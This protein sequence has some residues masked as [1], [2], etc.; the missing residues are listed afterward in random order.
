MRDLYPR[1]QAAGRALTAHDR[2]CA[3][4]A[5]SVADTSGRTARCPD[6]ARLDEALERLQAA[7]LTQLKS[8]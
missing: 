5:R 4:C 3:P 1:Y 8:R 2:G 6:G 7:Y